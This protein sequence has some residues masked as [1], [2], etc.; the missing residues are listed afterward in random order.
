MFNQREKMVELHEQ[1]ML[2]CEMARRLAILRHQM[3]AGERY[4]VYRQQT[5]DPSDRQTATPVKFQNFRLDFSLVPGFSV[6]DFIC[7]KN[8]FL[9]KSTRQI[10]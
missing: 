5:E 10:A 6:Q 3:P 4:N 1:G 9:L 8:C 2:N 7:Q